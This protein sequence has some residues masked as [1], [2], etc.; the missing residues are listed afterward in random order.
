MERTRAE[1]IAANRLK[2]I[3]PLP[4]TAPDRDK[5]QMLKEQICIQAGLSERTLRR[6]M[7][8]YN[9]EGFEG[10][11]P[12]TAGNSGKSVIPEEIIE[13]AI[14]LRREVP[15]RS[16]SGIIQILE[17]EGKIRPGTVRRSTLQDQL[18]YRGY[19]SRQMRTY[20]SS[21][22]SARRF[23]KPWR[24]YLWQS[25]YSDITIIPMF[26]LCSL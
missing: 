19:S 7:N 26:F 23:Q 18:S 5:R 11:K 8:Q 20:A 22:T 3:S 14:A 15:N 6:Y 24:N 9:R 16:V 17:W 4:D 2:L 25:D 12:H 10:L 13:E 21:V 1:E